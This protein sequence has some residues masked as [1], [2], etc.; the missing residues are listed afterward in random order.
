MTRRRSQ[1]AQVRASMYRG[2]RLLGDVRAV[3]TGR[4]GRR[5]ANRVIGRQ[6]GRLLRGIM[7]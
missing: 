3:Q 6:V 2:A 1:V 5:V 4:E 7:R